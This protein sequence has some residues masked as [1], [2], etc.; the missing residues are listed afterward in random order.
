MTTLFWFDRSIYFVSRS[1]STLSKR[2]KDTLSSLRNQALFGD[3]TGLQEEEVDRRKRMNMSSSKKWRR[4]EGIS[5]EEAMRRYVSFAL[6]G[7]LQPND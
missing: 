3:M 6:S 4:L 5:K 7:I 1:F 2:E